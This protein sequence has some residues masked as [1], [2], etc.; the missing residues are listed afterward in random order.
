MRAT[1][2]WSMAIY[3]LP[4]SRNVLL[5]GWQLAVLLQAQSGNPV[6]IVT[7]NSTLTGVANTRST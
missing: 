4:L 7:T 5:K 6:N 2:L 1:G 3:E